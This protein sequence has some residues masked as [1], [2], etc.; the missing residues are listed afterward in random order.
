MVRDGEDDDGECDDGERATRQ[1]Q[2]R[3]SPA[4]PDWVDSGTAVRRRYPVLP[5]SA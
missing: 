1:R 4:K 5:V 3:L 2:K